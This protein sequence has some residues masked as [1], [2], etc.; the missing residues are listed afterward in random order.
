MKINITLT[1]EEWAAAW[2]IGL[3]REK[4]RKESGVHQ[5]FDDNGG[6]NEHRN[7]IGAVTEYALAKHLGPD[8][9]KDWCENKSYAEGAAIKRILAD[10]GKNVQVRG[11]DA[12]HKGIVTHPRDP[13]GAV[14]V[15][16]YADTTTRT[17]TFVGWDFGGNLK[18]ARWW[19]TKKAGF[20]K[21]GRAAFLT[22]QTELKTMDT[23]PM[24]EVR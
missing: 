19:E 7:G 8:I 24:E 11:V 1:P 16:A 6:S 20:N 2:A 9:L 10:V 12:S 18:R 14:F 22:P 13:S 23:L 17:V 21:P 4:H 5:A 3:K 15:L